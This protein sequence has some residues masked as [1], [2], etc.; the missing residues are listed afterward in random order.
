MDFKYK[1]IGVG[2]FAEAEW[3]NVG[4]YRTTRRTVVQIFVVVVQLGD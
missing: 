1:K 2:A 3:A 4:F